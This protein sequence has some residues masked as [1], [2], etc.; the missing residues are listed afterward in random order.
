MMGFTLETWKQAAADKLRGIGGWLDRWRAREAPFLVYGTLCGL[1]LWPL[2]EA[3]QAGQFLPAVMA[4]GSIAGGVGGNLLAEQVQRWRD[5]AGQVDEAQVADWAAQQ[6]AANPDLRQAL[7]AILAHLEAIPHA[8]DALDS[9]GRAWFAQALRE[10]MRRLGNWTRFEATLQGAGAIAQ[11]GS[12]AAGA[13]GVAVGRDVQGDVLTSGARKEVHVHGP[14]EADPAALRAAYLHR[15]Y[16]TARHLSLAGVDPKAASS[17]AEAR[18]QLGAVYTALLTLS[19]ED[20]ARP[21]RGQAPERDLEKRRLSALA[22]LDRHPRLVLLGDPGSGKTTFVDFVTLC[23]AGEALGQEDANLAL[24]T[25]PLPMEPDRREERPA[26]QPWSHGP[27]LPVRVVLR[28]LAARGLPP[29]GERAT[30]GHLWRFLAAELKAAALGDYAPHLRQEL[31]ERGGL[32]LLDGLDEVPEADRRREQIKQAVQDFC[33]SFGRCRMLVTSRTYAYQKQD[34]RLRSFVEA[35]LAPFGAG[36]IRRFVDRW[37]AHVALLRGLHPDDAQGR[38]ALLKQAVSGS[39]RLQALAE[40]PLLLTLMA[41][42][43]AWRG[44]SLPEKREELYADTVDLLL[45][46]WESQRVVRDAAGEV[47]VMQPSLAEWLKVDRDKVR[48]LL[49]ELAYGAHATQPEL[50][51]SADVPEAD[52]VRG[53]LHLSDN[54]D[55]KQARLVEYLSQRAGLLLPRGVGVY[56]FPHRTFQEYLAACHLTDQDYPELVARLA[57]EEP[58][59]WR[60]VALLAGAKAARGTASAIWSL[61]DALCH[62][63]LPAEADQAAADAWGALL[64]GQAL[65]ES[66]NL[67]QVSERNRAKA[68]RVAAHLVRILETGRLP[69]VERAAAG[70][71]LALVGD[72]RPGVG[73]DPQTGLPG[74]V[75]C[76][77]PA[78]PFLM[79]SPD[80]SLALF[81]SETPQ[82]RVAMPAFWISK[83]PVTVAQFRAFVRA[84]G[85]R[86]GRYW[87]EARAAG[88]WKEGL[89]RGWRHQEPRDRP[90]DFGQPFNLPNHPVVGLSWYEALAFCRWL[91]ERLHE[92]G[93]IGSG[94]VVRLP[95]EAEWEKAAR[96]DDGRVYPW[97]DEFDPDRCNADDTGIG[98]T[99]AVGAFPGGASPH[100]LLDLSGNVWEWC[101]TQWRGSYAEPADES[102][103]GTARRVLRG[104]SFFSTQRNVRCAYRSGYNP[105]HRSDNIGFRVVVAPVA[106]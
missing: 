46:W 21:G 25:A 92:A 61:V 24:L 23:L 45:D 32:L 64:A 11:Q 9:A 71:A 33:A 4:L 43:H 44:G 66:A 91:T 75:Y 70:R 40:R 103:A 22:Q 54:P 10:E 18:L 17:Q 96:G 104:G 60:E 84:G 28:D 16:E 67:A 74:I 88:L 105:N 37:Y 69:A 26:P 68:D 59:R 2:L 35:V 82:H 50:E 65:G 106:L 55:V 39:E 36:Q 3:A 83:Y 81:G 73:V 47:V 99:S 15:L 86:A 72:P 87:A 19:T 1:S 34:W 101:Q 98:S 27:L 8:R 95:A 20:P 78:G 52:L 5:R 79:G 12:V 53:L 90:Y 38:A 48:D 93:G 102:L 41:S 31:L 94:Q 77:V 80:D 76:E 42:L 100:G 62:Q 51:G 13:M 30:A 29:S 14:D 85:Y 7:D 89:L 49:N 56:T 57:R 97:G 63:D 58:G 6:A